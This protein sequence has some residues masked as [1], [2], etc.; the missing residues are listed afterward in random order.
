MGHFMET[1]FAGEGAVLVDYVRVRLLWHINNPLRFQRIF[2]FG[3]AATVLKFR[4]EKLR[5]FY[6][7][8][9]MWSHDAG[10]CPNEENPTPD[11]PADDDDDDEDRFPDVPDDLLTPKKEMPMASNAAETPSGSKKRKTPPPPS[12][13]PEDIKSPQ[14]VYNAMRHTFAMEDTQEQFFKR[15]RGQSEVFERRDW[16]VVPTDVGSS[17]TTNR[18]SNATTTPTNN[19]DGTVGHKPPESG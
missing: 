12:S 17:S 6:T 14:L 15:K 5:N 10:E 7:L 11:E 13:V 9:G 2:Q 8:C 3:D 16:F 19:S 1:D 4:Y 18:G